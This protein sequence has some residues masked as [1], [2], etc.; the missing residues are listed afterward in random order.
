LI[1]MRALRRRKNQSIVMLDTLKRHFV[2]IW[3]GG[4]ALTVVTALT[5]LTADKPSSTEVA[6]A[7]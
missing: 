5:G 6:N 2:A 4:A 7:N 3:F 1:Q